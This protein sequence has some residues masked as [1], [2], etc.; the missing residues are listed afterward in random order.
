MGNAGFPFASQVPN[1]NAGQNNWNPQAPREPESGAQGQS[2][3]MQT[4]IGQGSLQDPYQT[5]PNL[6][7]SGQGLPNPTLNPQD[8][9]NTQAIQSGRMI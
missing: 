8:Y 1:I 2:H 7:I 3:I 5:G 4:G 9:L 6:P